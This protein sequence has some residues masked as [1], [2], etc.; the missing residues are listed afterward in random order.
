[1]ENSDSR[2]HERAT[3]ETKVGHEADIVR[4]RDLALFA[5]ALVAL[6]ILVEV[7][8]A[9]VM[10]GFRREESQPRQLAPPRFS[11]DSGAFPAPRLQSDPGAEYARFKDEELRRLNSYGWIDR[12]AGIAHIPI[13]RAMDILAGS[14]ATPPG[15]AAGGAEPAKN[16]L[17]AAAKTEARREA[18]KDR[19][20]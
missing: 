7:V 10:L 14:G 3:A 1:V 9:L 15:A 16:E 12:R 5:G 17:P 8:L 13:E 18:R 19:E 11:S 2:S 6:G 4:V 20:P